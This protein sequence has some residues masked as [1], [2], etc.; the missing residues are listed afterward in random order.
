MLSFGDQSLQAA[1]TVST[2]WHRDAQMVCAFCA[3]LATLCFSAQ[4]RRHHGTGVAVPIAWRRKATNDD[5][6]FYGQWPTCDRVRSVGD[7]MLVDG[8]LSTLKILSKTSRDVQMEVV[9][10][11]K[12][13][14]RHALS[15][16]RPQ[17][18]GL[19]QSADG[20]RSSL[21]WPFI[22]AAS[23]C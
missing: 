3:Q 12:L 15:L 14:S 1:M 7:I 21:H 5:M 2:A 19:V 17:L 18:R 4:R 9:D 22:C 11:G 23:G 10:G 6:P 16:A 13:T 8:G 20:S